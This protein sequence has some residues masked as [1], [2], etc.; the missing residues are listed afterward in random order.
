MSIL[1][2]LE[3]SILDSIGRAKKAKHIGVFATEESMEVAKNKILSETNENVMFNVYVIENLFEI[4][5]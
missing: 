5:N 1:Y 2:N 4:K 3:Y